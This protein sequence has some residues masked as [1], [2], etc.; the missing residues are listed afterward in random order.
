MLGLQQAQIKKK[1]TVNY[2]AKQ[3]L[4]TIEKKKFKIKNGDRTDNGF[5]RKMKMV[6]QTEDNNLNNH[7]AQ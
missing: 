6:L 3:L 5:T 2:V 4:K 1:Y 7:L